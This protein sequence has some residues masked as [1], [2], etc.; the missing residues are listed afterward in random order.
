LLHY[1]QSL[2]VHFSSILVSHGL[3][4]ASSAIAVRI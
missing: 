3:T 4:P 2:P 1:C